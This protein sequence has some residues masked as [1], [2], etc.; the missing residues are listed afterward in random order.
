LSKVYFSPKA[1][2]AINF[3]KIAAY[4]L[5]SFAEETAVACRSISR[6]K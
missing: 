1:S 2:A 5:R 6:L 3:A 4:G